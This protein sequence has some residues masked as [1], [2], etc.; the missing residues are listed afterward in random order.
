MRATLRRA[1]ARLPIRAIALPGLCSALLL[2]TLSW[3]QPVLFACFVFAS[4]VSLLG[5]LLPWLSLRGV[6]AWVH[7]DHEGRPVLHFRHRGGWPAAMVQV[8]TH[9]RWGAREVVLRHAVPWLWRR[10]SRETALAAQFPCR[11]DYTLS[12][13]KVSSGF[14][15]GVVEPSKRLRTGD[16]RHLVLPRAGEADLPPAGHDVEDPHSEGVSR[17]LGQSGELHMLLPYRPGDPLRRAHWRASARSGSLV[18]QHFHQSGAP[19][20]RL[21]CEL[22]DAE[23]SGHADAPAELAVRVAAGLVLQAAQAGMRVLAHLEPGRAAVSGAEAIYSELA[24]AGPAAPAG[25]AATLHSAIDAMRDGETLAIVLGT[26]AHA[27]SL[28]E[29]LSDSALRARTVSIFVAQRRTGPCALADAL[30]A[31]GFDVRASV[32]SDVAV[33]V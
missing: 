10:Q 33:A 32:V 18:I 23:E 6:D 5:M 31:A 24:A 27:A 1:M 19:V 13:L 16:F 20:M 25:L 21:V 28:L 8:E 26:E 17:R 9:W 7:A 22:P 14:P 4:V 3:P 2:A 15:L 12:M 30:R 29:S 11:G